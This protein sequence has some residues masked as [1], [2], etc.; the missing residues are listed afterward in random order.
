MIILNDLPLGSRKLCIWQ[1]R[2]RWGLHQKK[3]IFNLKYENLPPFSSTVVNLCR[4]CMFK[5]YYGNEC[6]QVLWFYLMYV[7]IKKYF[8]YFYSL[9]LNLVYTVHQIPFKIQ[10]SRTPW[11]VQIRLN[12]EL[13]LFLPKEYVF[14]KSY[15]I[16]QYGGQ[17]Y[18]CL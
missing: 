13:N 4:L 7:N 1:W 9:L 5:I 17:L 15:A 14:W 3:R 8:N 18:K 12:C 16:S 11:S 6:V 10:R 2:L